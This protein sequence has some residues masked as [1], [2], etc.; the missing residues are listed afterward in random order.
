M[1]RFALAIA[2]TMV[3]VLVAGLLLA[4]FAHAVADALTDL[5]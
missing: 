5:P 2:L 1:A 4:V 3:V